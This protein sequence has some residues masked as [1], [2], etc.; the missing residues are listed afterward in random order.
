MNGKIRRHA[1]EVVSLAKRRDA[2]AH[3]ASRFHDRCRT[4]DKRDGASNGGD[5][6]TH[7]V[8]N[9]NAHPRYESEYQAAL[10]ARQIT[11]IGFAPR[12]RVARV[13]PR[14]KLARARFN[15]TFPKKQLIIF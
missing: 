15:S 3:V 4:C 6:I 2:N 8:I 11:A 13:K 14:V 5:L 7:G 10:F 12:A 9:L 1:T